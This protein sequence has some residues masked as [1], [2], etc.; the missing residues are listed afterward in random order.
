MP[1]P[2]GFPMNLKE[3]WHITEYY[4]VDEDK[5]KQNKQPNKQKLYFPI[6]EQDQFIA[7]ITNQCWI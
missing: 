2:Q 6:A 3:N 7:Q 5:T 1:S 4:S